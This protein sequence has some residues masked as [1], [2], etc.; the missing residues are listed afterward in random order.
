[1]RSSPCLP[2]QTS[3]TSLKCLKPLCRKDLQDREALGAL[4]LSDDSFDD[5]RY[6]ERC[7]LWMTHVLEGC[8][9]IWN[10]LRMLTS[11]YAGTRY[12]VTEIMQTSRVCLCHSVLFPK[13][14]T[15]STRHLHHHN[16]GSLILQCFLA[17]AIQ[18]ST[19]VSLPFP[20]CDFAQASSP[21]LGNVFK[22]NHH[23]SPWPAEATIPMQAAASASTCGTD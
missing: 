2:Y 7:F 8:L 20:R 10:G 13:P 5:V 12:A 22:T 21:S 11:L 6:S 16:H 9:F 15:N 14:I 17:T 23:S 1:M 18:Q 19:F 4:C 3:K